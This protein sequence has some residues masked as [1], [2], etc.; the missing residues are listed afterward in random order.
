MQALGVPLDTIDRCQ[1][2]V[3]SGSKVPRHYL[4]HGYAAEK[5]DAW[6]AL[7][8][9]IDI[10]AAGNRLTKGRTDRTRYCSVRPNCEHHAR[11]EEF[12]TCGMKHFATGWTRICD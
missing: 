1:N 7:G 11:T 3:L 6:R 12:T 4:H 10:A 8:A 2:H 5:R 9:R